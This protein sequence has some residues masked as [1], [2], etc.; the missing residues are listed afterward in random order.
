MIRITKQ[1]DY[2]IVLLAHLAKTGPLELSTARD[3]AESAHLPLPMVSKILQLLMHKGLVVSQR[4]ATGG[5]R[6]ARSADEISVA[7]VIDAVEGPI[8]LTEC[9]EATPGQCELEPCCMLRSIWQRINVRVRV[10]LEDVSLT[11]MVAPVSI[12]GLDEA[13]LVQASEE[14]R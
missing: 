2:G 5:Y 3:L 13:T 6:L 10:A 4:G 1:S 14:I 7:E 8:G 9:I 11:E 12:H